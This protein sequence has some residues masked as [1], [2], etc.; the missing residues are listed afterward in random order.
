MVTTV[1]DVKLLHMV[2]GQPADRWGAQPAAG[3]LLRML[4]SRCVDD[5][6]PLL[7]AWPTVPW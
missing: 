7:A 3:A 5:A 2:Y 6:L 1:R 4:R